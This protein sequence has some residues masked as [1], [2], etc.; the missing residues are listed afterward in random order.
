MRELTVDLFIT[1]DGFAQGAR[2][3]AFFGYPG[4]DL[5][6]WIGEQL[7]APHVTLMGANTYRAMSQIAATGEDPSSARMSE[8]PK[9]VFSASLRPP[10]SWANTTVISEDVAVAVP[11]LKREGG[12]PMRVIGSLS[13]VRSLL[14]LGLVDRLRLMVFPQVL[15][16][17]GRQ[18]IFAGLP[19][20]N[21]RLAATR[22]LDGR[23]VLLDYAPEPPG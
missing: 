13:L 6:A 15:G 1:V 22:I 17:T 10:L 19:D 4:P 12:D 8:L 5:D 23:L 18:P 7:G 11:A 21:L 16:E 20:L 14:R 9:V 2:S 3:P